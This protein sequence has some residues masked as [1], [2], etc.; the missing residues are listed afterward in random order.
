MAGAVVLVVGLIAVVLVAVVGGDDN[1]PEAQIRNTIGSYTQ[2]LKNGDLETLR[3]TTCG[4]LHEFYRGIPDD[5]FAGV[6]QQSVEQGSIPV[7]EHIQAIRITENTAIA[8][9]TV[10]TKADP[11]RSAR[12]F[13]LQHTE[14]GWK[15]CDPPDSAP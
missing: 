7:V 14:D 3:S 12:T 11:A 2:A 9:A 10:Y 8:Q 13:D 6:H 5:Q 1:S 4:S 15:V